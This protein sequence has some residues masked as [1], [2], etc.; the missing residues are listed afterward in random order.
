MPTS[1]F[2]LFILSTALSLVAT[3]TAVG[4]QAVLRRMIRADGEPPRLR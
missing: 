1:F 4:V 2:G 3:F